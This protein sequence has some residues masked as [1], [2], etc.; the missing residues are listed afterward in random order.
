MAAL[1]SC[2][3]L[4]I[5]GTSGIVYPA[6]SFAALAKQ[7]GAFIAEVNLDSTPNSPV[8]DVTIQGRAKEIVPQLLQTS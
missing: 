3:V 8:V 6:A 5:I 1:R 7:A 2:E 4:L